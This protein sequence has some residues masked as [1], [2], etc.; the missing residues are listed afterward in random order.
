MERRVTR[1]L[2]NE[3]QNRG[4]AHEVHHHYQAQN[5]L[6]PQLPHSN[7]RPLAATNRANSN[8]L[9]PYRSESESFAFEPLRTTSEEILIRTLV[10]GAI[11]Q[12]TP[13]M[14]GL[15][16]SSLPLASRRNSEELFSTWLNN[17]DEPFAATTPNWNQQAFGSVSNDMS[18][19]IPQQVTASQQHLN[20]QQQP[21]LQTNF[22]FSHAM[23][24]VGKPLR[25]DGNNIP[26]AT[27]DLNNLQTL[28]WFQQ[29]R[30][31]TRSRSAEL[32]QMYAEMQGLPSADTVHRLATQGTHGLNQAVASLGAFARGLANG[33]IPQSPQVTHHP[34]SSNTV[35]TARPG[36]SISNMVSMLRGSLERKKLMQMNQKNES[37]M[38]AVLTSGLC[39]EQMD[40]QRSAPSGNISADEAQNGCQLNV[41]GNNAIGHPKS[42]TLTREVSPCESS[43][44][45]PT[46]STGVASSDG[47]SNSGMVPTKHNTLKRSSHLGVAIDQPCKKL[48]NEGSLHSPGSHKSGDGSFEGFPKVSS[49][50][51]KP[52]Q[53]TRVGSLVSSGRSGLGLD[54][55]NPTKMRRVERREKMLEA[56]GRPVLPSDSQVAMKRC[57]ALE[58]EVRSLKLTVS[59]MNRK[60]SEQTKRIEE[61][62]KENQ[63]LQ[64]EKERL[65]E[66]VERLACGHHF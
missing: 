2:S 33:C 63:E 8:G 28:P 3:L 20:S 43:G 66:E 16:L 45:A 52:E 41:A 18:M 17:E 47:L 24:T 56:K 7:S 58:K 29:A 62:E 30:P 50:G 35:A 4:Q 53:L 15:G 10:D 25:T 55:A 12:S 22:S 1:S 44:G 19:A 46:L 37:T 36:N 48:N 11:T 51:K 60:D 42:I 64:H 54:G 21:G 59:F 38:V 40:P 32:R 31:M 57:D 65:L 9:Q 26:S 39:P 13:S 5:R 27:C 61:L 49:L 14:D 23:F 34:Q 6:Q